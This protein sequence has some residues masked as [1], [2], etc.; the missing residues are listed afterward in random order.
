MS[1]TSEIHVFVNDKLDN[2]NSITNISK[3]V[4]SLFG[5]TYDEAKS[6]VED[7]VNLRMSVGMKY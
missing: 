2:N 6:K 7:I 3:S 5:I 4:S 1:K